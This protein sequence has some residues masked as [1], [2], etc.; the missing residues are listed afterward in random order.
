[1]FLGKKAKK[2]KNY[3]F[4]CFVH[5]IINKAVVKVVLLQINF[6]FF[7]QIKGSIILKIWSGCQILDLTLVTSSPFGPPVLFSRFHCKVLRDFK[8]SFVVI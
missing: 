4:K 1:M 7:Y 8:T 6:F 5:V 2:I 3:V